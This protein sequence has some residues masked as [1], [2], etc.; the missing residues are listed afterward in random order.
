MPGRFELTVDLQQRTLVHGEIY[1]RAA[2]AD[3]DF[4]QN[5]PAVAECRTLAALF[6]PGGFFSPGSFATFTAIRRAL[7]SPLRLRLPQ[8]LRQL[9]D[10]AATP[11][12]VAGE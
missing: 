3:L 7:S 11:H 10:I 5:E 2:P 4:D 1:Y 9:G 8:Q 12:L 6:H